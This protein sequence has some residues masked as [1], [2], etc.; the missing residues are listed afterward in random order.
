MSN[1]RNMRHISEKNSTD[2][3][4]NLPESLVVEI[5]RVAARSGHDD[6]RSEEARIGV[7]RIVVDERRLGVQRVRHGL[8]EDRRGRDLL[9]G[10]VEA[11]R[12]VATLRQ[13][14]AHEAAVWSE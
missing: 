1:T 14:Q 9:R 10:R 8:E 2:I 3:V 5:P 12:Q 6:L 11:V 7:Q 13:V 4:A